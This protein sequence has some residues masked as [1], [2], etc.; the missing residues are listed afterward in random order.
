[1]IKENDRKRI[2]HYYE[3]FRD[4]VREIIDE[5]KNRTLSLAYRT[6]CNCADHNLKNALEG[7]YD[8]N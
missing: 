1:M 2:M 6:L 8:D 3:G 4:S 5:Q 7:D